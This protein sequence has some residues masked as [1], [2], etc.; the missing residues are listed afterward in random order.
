[1]ELLLKSLCLGYEL[2]NVGEQLFVSSHGILRGARL[3]LH[4]NDGRLRLGSEPWR[5]RLY[6]VGPGPRQ[7]L[8]IRERVSD[9]EKQHG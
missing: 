2:L 6:I 5:S 3:R 7:S 1:V 4:D 8:P 9:A